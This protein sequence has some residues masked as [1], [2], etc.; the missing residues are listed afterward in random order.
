MYL[1]KKALT[2]FLLP[3]GIFIVCLAGLGTLLLLRKK[4]IAGIGTLLVACLLW[5]LSIAPV[6]N[7]LFRSL[8]SDFT[9]PRDLQGD[10]IILLSGGIYDRAPDLSGVGAPR[11]ETLSRIVTTARL[12]KQ[13]RVPV[14]V[15]GGKEEGEKPADAKIIK[16]FLVDLGIPAKDIIVETRSRD[17]IENAKFT[18]EIC[19]RRGYKDPILVT[20]AYHLKRSVI[21]FKKAGLEISPF[22]AGF[23]SWEN[24]K[25]VW[26][27]YLPHRTN[28]EEVSTAIREHMGL[29]FYKYIY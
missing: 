18:G 10:V 23:K 29:L 26:T 11:G 28:L 1:L 9:M 27:D 12:Q 4:R 22:P 24:R 15:S 25:Y 14:I 3:P 17:T 13:I 21:S 8:E 2:P 19:T 6:S 20:C 5:T 7:V 16:R